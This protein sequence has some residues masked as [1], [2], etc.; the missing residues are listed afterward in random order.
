[1]FNPTSLDEVCV[2]VTHLEA[3]GKNISDEGRKK[4]FK[5]KNKEKASK[6]KGKKN[7]Y[8]KKEGEKLFFKHF[9]RKGHGEKNCWKLHPE[10]RSKHQ[11]N[12]GKQKIA[13]ITQHG[14]GEDSGDECKITAMGLNNLKG[15]EIENKPITSASNCPI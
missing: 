13:A 3:R 12:K 6:G 4:P 15:K 5:G 8:V 1:M 11:N 7:A 10:Q 14:L 9:S 2:Q